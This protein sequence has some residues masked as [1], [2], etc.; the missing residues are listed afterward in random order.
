MP[1]HVVV[2][3][4]LGLFAL[5]GCGDDDDDGESASTGTTSAAEASSPD[6]ADV[7]AAITEYLAGATSQDVCAVMSRGLEAAI[8][9]EGPV[10]DPAA[11]ASKDCPAT[12]KKAAAEGKY[13]LEPAEPEIE[14]TAVAGRLAAVR[15]VNE[16][17]GG[18]EPYPVF[19]VKTADG[20]W[21][22][23]AEG[24]PPRE[25]GFEDLAAEVEG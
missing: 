16:S 7:E 3:L 6:K 15:I 18:S 21:L 8:S 12:I 13:S 4:L 19:L 9:G 2:L 14:E 23:H 5:A 25:G 17:A 22:I 10:G 24:E 1:R 11:P 20:K